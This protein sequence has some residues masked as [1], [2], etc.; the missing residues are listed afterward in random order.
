ME[1]AELLGNC[2]EA[3]FTEICWLDHAR[4]LLQ[5]DDIVKDDTLTWAANLNC[6]SNSNHTTSA[7]FL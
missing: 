2:I 3:T 1:K 7:T 4:V 6:T 5:K